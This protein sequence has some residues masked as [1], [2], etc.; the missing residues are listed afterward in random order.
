MPTAPFD[1]VSATEALLATVPPDVAARSD[2]YFEGGY[3][4][5]LWGT[6]VSVAAA[7]VL[8]HFGLA[9]RMRDHAERASRRPW[10]SSLLFSAAFVVA[11]TGLELPWSI[12]ADFVREHRYELAT[13]SFGEWIVE[14]GISL[15]VSVA[16]FAPAFALFYGLIRRAGRAWWA[17]GSALAIALVAFALLIQPV[18][19]EPLFNHYA[20]LEPGA[21]REEILSLARANGVPTDDVLVV[22][23]SRQTNRISANVAGLFGTARI[24]LSDNLLAQG[25]P[26]E[27]LAVTA[28]EIGHFALGHVS[29][30]LIQ[31][32]LAF[33]VGFLF[34]DRVFAAVHRRHGARFGVRDLADPA[35]LPILYAAFSVYLLLMTPALN[36]IIRV[37]ESQADLFALN[38][39]RQPDGFASIALKLGSHRKLAPGPLEEALMFDHPSGRSRILMAM[40]WKAEH[41]GEL[42]AAEA[43]ELRR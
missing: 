23:S 12:Y 43:S 22:D 9:A 41:L 34:A 32:G 19:I 36:T 8:L 33:G 31:L 6:L 4:L 40:R 13:Q 37:N 42:A 16:L 10:L 7:W 26:E 27:I 20:P 35:G 30:L 21:L 38:A 11:S 25:T 1:P 29:T 5:L 14:A 17:W 3:W 15:A 28:H 24:A 39:A 18:Y 2:A